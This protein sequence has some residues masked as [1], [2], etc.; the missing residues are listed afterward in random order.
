MKFYL[1]ENLSDTIAKVARQHGVDVISSHESGR[2]SLSDAEQ[3]RLAALDGRCLV[4]RDGGDFVAQT[5]RVLANDAP[6]AGVLIVTRALHL[7]DVGSIVRALV[8]YHVSHPGD[9]PAYTVDYLRPVTT[10]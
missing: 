6:H 8:D 1:D 5:F 2:N 4:T 3:L 10:G 7:H 9:H